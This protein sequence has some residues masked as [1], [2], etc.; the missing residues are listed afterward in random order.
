M[1]LRALA[2][3]FLPHTPAPEA[4]AG[5]VS[6]IVGVVLLALKF[7]AYLFTGSAAIFSDAMES[8]VNVAASAFALYALFYAHRP[9][10][11]EHPYGHGKIEFMSAGFEGGMIFA[12]AL[13]IGFRAV[14]AIV[15]RPPIQA[16]ALGLVLMGVAMVVN[17][18]L[19]LYLIRAGRRH[20]SLTLE[21]DGKHLLTDAVTSAAAIIAIVGVKLTGWRIIDP[22]FALLIALYITWTAVGLMRRGA[23]G[24]MDEQDLADEALLKRIL[25]AHLA[26]QGKEPQIC[27]YHKLRHRHNG[28]Y[29]WVDFHIMVP[30]TLNVERAHAIA[31]AIE[32]EIELAL[33]EGNATAHI[34]PCVD[35]ACA[36]CGAG[37]R[38]TAG[39]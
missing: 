37:A 10:D 35:P 24:L 18:A 29:H 17:G 26:P 28:R 7:L 6:V 38:E 31:S 21:A 8:I 22:I 3:K 13:V 33:G 25:D 20:H 36:A 34:E 16:I 1:P 27:S 39:A 4:V 2:R 12:A 11:R 19:G 5:L 14:E 32:Y 30:P 15:H 23:A 9:A